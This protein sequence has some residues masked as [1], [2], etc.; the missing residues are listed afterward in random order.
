MTSFSLHKPVVATNVGG[1]GEMIED[2][3]NGLLVTPKDSDALAS[4][5]ISLLEDRER[6][7]SMSRYICEEYEQGNRSWSAIADKYI[8][9]Y[10]KIL[11]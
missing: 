6:L 4:A 10:K 2:G 8:G 9:F 1:L 5:I 7:K 3:K 11:E